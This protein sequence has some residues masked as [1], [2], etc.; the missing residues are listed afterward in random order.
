M[1]VWEWCPRSP[2]AYIYNINLVC[3]LFT[4]LH[5]SMSFFPQFQF[6][7]SLDRSMHYL[8]IYVYYDICMYICI[9]MLNLVFIHGCMYQELSRLQTHLISMYLH[10]R[11]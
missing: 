5:V 2:R 6:M 10:A 9:Y 4:S 11:G 3:F 8:K 7:F 1:N